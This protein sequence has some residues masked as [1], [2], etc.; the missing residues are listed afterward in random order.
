[1]LETIATMSAM[2]EA[3][4]KFTR[5]EAAAEPRRAIDLTALVTSI[6][7]DLSDAGLAVTT[8]SA[9]RVIYECQPVAL[10]RAIANLIENAVRY[11]KYAHVAVASRP[12]TIE[13]TIDDD[14]PG[15]PEEELQAVSQP[16]YRLDRSRDLEK[17]GIGL[18]LAI[19][20]SIVEA[21]GGSL[22]LSNR[23]GGGLRAAITLPR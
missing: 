6:V 3:F 20:L 23:P 17:A 22:T 2:I 1:M 10:R 13:I 11:G 18:G 16:F 8:T 4:L 12:K 19:A 21:H 15:I 14:G 5:D 9:S 7:D